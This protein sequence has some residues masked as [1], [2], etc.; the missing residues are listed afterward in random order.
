MRHHISDLIVT[1]DFHLKQ[2]GPPA[3]QKTV[4]CCL[5]ITIRLKDRIYRRLRCN[6]FARKTTLAGKLQYI[7]NHVQHTSH[8]TCK[9]PCRND[10]MYDLLHGLCAYV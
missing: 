9:R 2:V 10:L 3:N 5:Q 4:H 6:M 1:T 7:R 8:I